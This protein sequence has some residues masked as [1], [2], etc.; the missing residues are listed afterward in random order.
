MCVLVRHDLKK[1]LRKQLD[2]DSDPTAYD[3][4]STLIRSGMIMLGYDLVDPL[5]IALDLREEKAK[6]IRSFVGRR[7]RLNVWIMLIVGKSFFCPQIW[8]VIDGD[9]TCEI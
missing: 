6:M 3:D 7:C 5:G 9:G 2:D 1:I 4:L 8:A